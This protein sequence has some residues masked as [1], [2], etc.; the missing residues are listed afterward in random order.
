MRLVRSIAALRTAMAARLRSGGDR[1]HE[2]LVNR[3]VIGTAIGAYSLAT[4]PD[5]HPGSG[6]LHVL[7]LVY[8]V[9]ALLLML[10][11]LARPGVSKARRLIAVVLDLGV[12]SLGLQVG[13]AVSAPFFPMYLWVILGNGFRFGMPWLR[14]AAVLSL[15]GFGLVLAFTPYWS[16]N[17]PL[18]MGLLA[19]LLAI[20]L[21]AGTLIRT[22]SN[23]R[24]HAEAANKAKSLFLASVSHELRTPLNAVIGM[25]SLINATRLDAEQR[26]MAGTIR[27]AS[28]S[29]LSLIDGILDLSR[30]EAGQMP[31]ADVEFD[32]CE[33]MREVMDIAS[34]KGREKGLR[35]SL[36]I[37]SRTP[38]DLVGDAK[39]LREVLV[40]LLS[41][42]V[43]FTPAGSVLLTADVVPHP[44]SGCHLRI[45]VSDTGI[46]IAEASQKRVFEDFVQADGSI[47]NRFGGTGLGLAITRRLVRL[48]AGKLELHSAEG[49]GSTFTVTVP[50]ARAATSPARL[51]GA[52]ITVGSEDARKLEPVLDRLRRI[53]CGI[54]VEGASWQPRQVSEPSAWLATSAH[55]PSVAC[56]RQIILVEEVG[57]G[58]SPP[59]FSLPGFSPMEVRQQFCSVLSWDAS[60]EDLVSAVRIATRKQ[61]TADA[62]A[63]TIWTRPRPLRVLV[64]DDNAVNIR[65]LELVLKRAGHSALVVTDGEQ[66]LDAMMEGG[67]DVVLMDV[68]MPV[69]DGVEATQLYRFNT[70][71]RTRLPILGLTADVSGEVNRRCH[72]AGMDECL[73]K[74]IEPGLL[75]DALDVATAAGQRD[76][77][78]ATPNPAAPAAVIASL[79]TL[80]TGLAGAVNAGTLEQL[81]SL[82]GDDFLD[83]LIDT[84]LADMGT[85][86]ASLIA[87]VQ[88]KDMA[89]LGAEAHA[90]FSAAGNM[91]AEP[92]RQV[93]RNLQGLTWLDLASSGGQLLQD[94]GTELG[95]VRVSL[96]SVRSA[97]LSS[98]A[99][100]RTFA[101]NVHPLTS[102][103]R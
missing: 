25:T 103:R 95:R 46:G 49:Q 89:A 52:S 60:N 29:L 37:T 90:L 1:E 82:G 22:L 7:R 98:A 4:V 66:A 97:D 34:V 47:M 65:V 38:L 64:A 8:C 36:H 12:L 48:L 5:G 53:G 61:V 30:I 14:I 74:P 101:A 83:D 92:L 32:L 21:Y 13:G 17:L 27:N 79:P 41:N 26:E 44:P 23:A 70:A 9:G 73:L 88:A 99:G 67:F 2:M 24:E 86:H 45:E 75:L 77:G 6:A 42:A 63:G 71:G 56:G 85:L 40:N 96:A 3:L 58:F 100:E 69:M 94:L 11:L 78:H 15:L 59:R 16:H 62:A 31:V 18:G 76:H 19:S 50:V 93:C 20:P 51:D 33:L 102:L 84:F 54:I 35:M 68:N 39:H 55:A 87:A 72:D 81:R 10:H 28:K 91:G 57:P 80:R 43:K